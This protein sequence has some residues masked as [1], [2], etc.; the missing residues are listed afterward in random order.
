MTDPYPDSEILR[1]WALSPIIS[2]N[3]VDLNFPGFGYTNTHHDVQPINPC[4]NFYLVPTSSS[5]SAGSSPVLHPLGSTGSST[6]PVPQD[7]VSVSPYTSWT[8][9]DPGSVFDSHSRLRIVSSKS[10]PFPANS[11]TRLTD[12]LHL[13][14][15]GLVGKFGG[16][17]T[18]FCNP[19]EWTMGPLHSQVSDALLKADREDQ[20]Y[21]SIG[22]HPY[23]ADQFSPSGLAQL[24]RLLRGGTH[25]LKSVVAL[26]QCGLDYSVT[27]KVARSYQRRVFFDQLVL[28]LKYNL[29][30][31]LYI[32]D[33]EEDGYQILEAAGV[34]TN[35]QLHRHNFT[36]SWSTACAWLSRYPS[37]KIGVSGSITFNDSSPLQHT[38]RQ[39]PLYRL[40]LATDAPYFLPV[41]VHKH[42]YK[43][44]LSQPGHLIRVATKVA[45]LKNISVQDVLASNW[46]NV[47][48][49]YGIVFHT[50]AC[51]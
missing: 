24:E 5:P 29:P 42:L 25:S 3:Y 32:R 13:A 16:C 20:V 11:A 41:G 33:A 27:N 35:Y 9:L 45:Q 39:I 10:S 48:E 22:I 31:V 37:S 17:I 4:H 47:T 23:F 2:V 14:G 40:L 50:C 38:V 12:S 8:H 28:G 46:R 34:P 26:G 30:L 18:T 19:M 6:A 15:R 21:L 36:G 7:L 43:F 49:I 51:M 1:L 44:S